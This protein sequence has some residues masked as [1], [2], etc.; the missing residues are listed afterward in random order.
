MADDHPGG[1]IAISRAIFEHPLFKRE[2]KFSRLE[3]WEWL[4]ARA[5]WKPRGQRTAH[6]V[7]HLDRRQL[8]VTERELAQTW[9]WPKTNVHRFLLRLAKDSMIMLATSRPGPK[10]GPQTGAATG[11]PVNLITICNYEKFQ[12]RTNAVK[13]RADQKPDQKPDQD[14]PHLPGIIYESDAEQDNHSNHYS[15][16]EARGVRWVNLEKPPHGAQNDKMVWYDY[17]TGDWEEYAKNYREVRG[18]EI[19][20]ERRRGGSGNW[21]VKLGEVTRKRRRRA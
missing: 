18:V 15:S 16:K 12:N 9:Q 1:Y 2:R 11:Y 13:R 17:P 19:M 6:G 14:I 21:F 7:I 5:A 3:A 8:A 4:I 20:P 10:A